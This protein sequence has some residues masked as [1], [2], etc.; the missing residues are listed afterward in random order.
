MI[1]FYC[2]FKMCIRKCDIMKKILGTMLMFCALV[3]PANAATVEVDLSIDGRVLSQLGEKYSTEYMHADLDFSD[4]VGF[5]E[6]GCTFVP[7]RLVSEILGATVTWESPNAIIEIGDDTLIMEVG[8]KIATKN[9]EALS[10]MPQAAKNIDGSI[11]VPIRFVAQAFGIYVDYADRTVIMDT[12]VDLTFQGEAVDSFYEYSWMTMGGY[13]NLFASN[14]DAQRFLDALELDMENEVDAPEY[15]S[16]GFVADFDKTYMR[17][18]VYFI[19]D[20]FGNSLKTFTVY[21]LKTYDLPD[22]DYSGLEKYLIKVDD[23]WYQ[24][25]NFI[26]AINGG[27]GSL[28]T[29]LNTVA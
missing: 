15:V 25:D 1:Y 6:D 3:L 28:I 20:E 27:H 29:V 24:C 23:R 7:L 10:E 19:G 5:N 13:T 16:N 8:S 11:Y 17:S 21:W 14:A 9:G 4:Y 22:V 26:N 18:S 2:K 12:G